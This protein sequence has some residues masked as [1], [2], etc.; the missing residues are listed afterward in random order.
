[1]NSLINI[2][3]RYQMRIQIPWIQSPGQYNTIRISIHSRRH[4][5]IDFR[6]F[7]CS[8]R[9]HDNIVTG[10]GISCLSSSQ[11]II[12]AGQA[13]DLSKYGFRIITKFTIAVRRYCSYG[14]IGFCR[15][16]PAIVYIHRNV[17]QWFICDCVPQRT[18]KAAHTGSRD[19]FHFF[20]KV[21]RVTFIYGFIAFKSN[22]IFLRYFHIQQ[23]TRYCNLEFPIVICLR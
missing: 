13:A 8:S 20:H 21:N 1:M 9:V 10:S 4:G 18:V 22:I 7:I 14:R 6:I 12:T 19:E 3:I 5:F 23:A 15:I 17:I 16:V 11:G 2:C